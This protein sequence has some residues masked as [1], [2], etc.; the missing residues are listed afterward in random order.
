[1]S[2]LPGG[3]VTFLFTD[4]EGS[5][6]LWEESPRLMMEALRQHDRAIEEAIAAYRGISVKPRGEGD[7]RFVVFTDAFDAVAAAA[8]IQR[9]LAAT[10]WVTPS[11]LRVRASVHTGTADLSF[12]DYYGSAVNRAARLRG[13]AHGG[14]TVVSGVT[15]GLVRD[16]L[17]D[18]VALRDMGE[19]GLKDLSRPEH[20]FQLDVEGLS[21]AFPP[22]RSLQ[23]V[24]HN[25]PTQL[26]EFVGREDRAF[27]R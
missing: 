11:A 26:T 7:S 6:R 27:R 25:L 15:G 5:T 20:V 13:I 22:L 3:V 23:R 17:P 2:D 24:P 21:S 1:M 14:Q 10:D 4:V 9:R 12:G 19:H 16:R 18:G 8:D